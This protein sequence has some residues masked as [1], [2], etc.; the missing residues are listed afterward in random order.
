MAKISAE[1]DLAEASYPGDFPGL[2]NSA[3]DNGH[4]EKTRAPD[5]SGGAW[6]SIGGNRNTSSPPPVDAVGVPQTTLTARVENIARSIG[7]QIFGKW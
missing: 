3:Q 5:L 2:S 1:K 4:L 6:G 7:T